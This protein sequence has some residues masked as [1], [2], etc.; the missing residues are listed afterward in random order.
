MLEARLEW[1]QDIT[2]ALSEFVDFPEVNLPKRKFTDPE[3]ITSADIE[4]AAD[5]CRELWNLGS[6]SIPDLAMAVVGTQD[7]R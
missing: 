1:A 4:E 5:E 7:Y 6:R 3:E 2:L